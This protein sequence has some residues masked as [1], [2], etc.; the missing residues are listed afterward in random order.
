MR[1]GACDTPED[2]VRE[3]HMVIEFP[4]Y[5]RALACYRSPEYQEAVKLPHNSAEAEIV[6]VEGIT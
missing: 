3:R 5:E 1:G 6:I 2:P 4:S